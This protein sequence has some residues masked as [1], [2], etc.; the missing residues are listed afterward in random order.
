M[1]GLR[2]GR[3]PAPWTVRRVPVRVLTLPAE[4]RL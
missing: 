1:V 4:L 2:A 3:R